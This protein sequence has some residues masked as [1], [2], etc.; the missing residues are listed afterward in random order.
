MESLL[1]NLSR[2]FA[3]QSE[4]GC[5]RRV[6]H[7]P[8][9]VCP[10]LHRFEEDVQL[11]ELDSGIWCLNHS[12]RQQQFY[13]DRML[14]TAFGNL[15]NGNDA[16][17]PALLKALLEEG[18]VVPPG[19]DRS[20][21]RSELMERES[22]RIA[23]ESKPDFRLLRVLLTD[24]CNLA[25]SYCK[26]VLN[27]KDARTRPTDADRLEDAVRFFFDNSKEA[28]P[29]IIHITGGEPTIH[30]G[31]ILRILDAKEAYSRQHE[32]C[33][34]VL[35]TNAT[36]LTEVDAQEFA[37]RGVKC[38]VS[39]DGPEEIHN[40]LRTN[41]AGRGSWR[42][43]DTGLKKLK[44]AGV[45]VSI[46]MVIGRHNVGDLE[47]VIEW[48]LETYVPS[49]L[50][51]NFMKA[52]TP[53]QAQFAHRIT[54]G[55]Y[56]E[57]LYR[58]HRRFRDRGVF[59]ELPFRKVDPFV[60]QYYRFHDCGAAEG[61]NLNIDSKGNLGPCK[62]FLVRGELALS[63]LTAEGY[64]T[65]VVQ[66]WRR[67]SPIYYDECSGCPARGMCGNGCAYE[68]KV[69]TGN[70]MAVDDGACGYTQ[71]F[72]QLM[73]AELGEIV[74]ARAARG[75]NQWWAIPSREERQRIAG[76][77]GAREHTLSYSIGHP[78]FS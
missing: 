59:L 61:A 5:F 38:I 14:A 31:H 58:V 19:G 77:V 12:L 9:T 3:R 60:S 21:A 62:S 63:D 75:G 11:I 25:C 53:E 56:A 71:Y 42:S 68:A 47:E 46:S 41:S 73:V 74:S 51:V 7:P 33:W 6:L 28:S 55:A 70:E 45:E 49:G 32:N 54:P 44:A 72:N 2:S 30:R 40:R 26:V 48:V 4:G 66:K 15:A 76:F 1:M 22:R 18:F 8:G 10:T 69:G 35:G 78:R 16:C 39:M 13:G 36:L 50:G 24:R 43:V 67:R 29:K 23:G 65:A 17:D 34:V 52:P 64:Q 20:R 27:T 57:T 37:R